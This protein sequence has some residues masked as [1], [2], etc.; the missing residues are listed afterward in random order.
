MEDIS[1]TLTLFIHATIAGICYPRN[2]KITPI[3]KNHN[4]ISLRHLLYVI[5][6]FKK[7]YRQDSIKKLQLDWSNPLSCP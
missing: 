5:N 2:Y 6:L 3:T 1:I 7:K 4:E